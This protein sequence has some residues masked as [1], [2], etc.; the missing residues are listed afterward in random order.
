M[1]FGLNFAA[2][3]VYQM[4]RGAIVFITAIM[5]VIFL[6]NKQYRHHIV[7]LVLIIIG[8]TIVGVASVTMVKPDEGKKS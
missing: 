7:S 3:S 5:S 2:A 1:F 8:I 4:M 6:K